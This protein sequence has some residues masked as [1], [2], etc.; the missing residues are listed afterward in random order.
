MVP[1]LAGRGDK[2]APRGG[3]WSSRVRLWLPGLWTLP[4]WGLA[5]GPAGAMR[6]PSVSLGMAFCHR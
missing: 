3:E 5:K 2:D 4:G 6:A 1:A